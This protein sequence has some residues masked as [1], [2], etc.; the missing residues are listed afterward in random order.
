[1]PRSK[2]GVTKDR[3]L[4]AMYAA[5]LQHRPSGA[6]DLI[7]HLGLG[8]ST[9]SEHL[10]DLA[11]AT[12]ALVA[13]DPEQPRRGTWVLTPAG[14]EQAAALAAASGTPAR[15]PLLARAVAPL[16]AHVP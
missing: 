7:A 2:N 5:H 8:A 13:P 4:L 3:I 15:K 6:A 1:M 14:I 9:V 10:A 12:P 16:R 11:R